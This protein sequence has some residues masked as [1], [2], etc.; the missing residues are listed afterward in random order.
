[1]QINSSLLLLPPYAN[2]TVLVCVF[3]YA[4]CTI[5]LASVKSSRLWLG[6]TGRR[7]A[8]THKHLL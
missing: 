8:A 2:C 6:V 3:V 7:P 1:M 4:N 5:A